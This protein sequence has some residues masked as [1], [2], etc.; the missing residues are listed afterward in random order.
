MSVVIA[1]VLLT[2]VSFSLA[3]LLKQKP[4]EILPGVMMSAVLVLF[5]FYCLDLLLPGTL[6][7][8]MLGAGLMAAAIFRLHREKSGA[9]GLFSPGICLFLA[10]TLFFLLYLRNNVSFRWD[11]LRLWAAMPKALHET[12]A[13]QLKEDA[14]IFPNMRS[15]PPGMH[16]LCWL[17]TFF[18]RDFREYQLFVTYALL[19]AALWLPAL[20]DLKWKQAPLLLPL[21]AAIVLLPCVLTS[22]GEDHVYFYASLFIDPILGFLAGY[23]FYLA[24]RNP[25]RSGTALWQ[26]CAALGMLTLVKD[27][28]ALF[29][30][31]SLACALMAQKPGKKW[32]LPAAA[33]LGC[34]LIWSGMLRIYDIHSHLHMAPSG[35]LGEALVNLLRHLWVAP[36]IAVPGV[37]NP[38]FFLNFYG[39]A[40][41][42][43]AI[44]IPAARKNPRIRGFGTALV[45]LTLCSMAFLLGVYGLFST[46]Y[47]S[48]QRYA[49]ALTLC[50]TFLACLLALE[51]L[52]QKE[53]PPLRR[54]LAVLM[55]CAVLAVT[56]V[57]LGFWK[58][59]FF[60]RE[61][62]R[63][64]DR[65]A[66]EILEQLPE[67]HSRI[68]LLMAGPC[69]EN[70]LTHH[71]V[72]F[73]LLGTRGQIC[74]FWSEVRIVPKD[75]LIDPADA[76]AL[77]ALSRSW[78]GQLREEDY[79]YVYVCSSEALADAV[80]CRLT[81]GTPARA[82]HLYRVE[83]EG[84]PQVL[85]DVTRP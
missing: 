4:E 76:E 59:C 1:V 48:F 51:L 31:G 20:A 58:T 6:L 49:T 56:L 25:F 27:S 42:F 29:A 44:A 35:S 3:V 23:S 55:S 65:I 11:E 64:S 26:F 79:D 52:L 82:G 73:D 66:G 53:L 12:Q 15:Y 24:L 81:D 22:H 69:V 72:Y 67:E 68:Y 74:N 10:L 34:W 38:R 78:T 75:A 32:I 19:M 50:L 21:A 9:G 17:F 40:G 80:F 30:L 85:T 83:P 45:I 57:L 63:D 43:L 61:D 16:L 8:L 18:Q 41:I 5:P 14:L 54:S 39:V 47:S 36:A 7:L 84:S 60:T 62:L 37:Q 77:N 46:Q 2:G 71:R 70:S 33:L 28:G 13:L